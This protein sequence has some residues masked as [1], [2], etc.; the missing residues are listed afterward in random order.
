MVKVKIL[1]KQQTPRSQS[2]SHLRVKTLGEYRNMANHYD[3]ASFETC[4]VCLPIA[5]VN[6]Q[7][8]T[9]SSP[10]P[11]TERKFQRPPNDRNNKRLVM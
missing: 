7:P 5:A 11:V 9:I 8:I 2:P 4:Q 6:G 3:A 10:F 1:H